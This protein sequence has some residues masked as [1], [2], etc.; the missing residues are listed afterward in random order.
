[1]RR[2]KEER[3][4]QNERRTEREDVYIYLNDTDTVTPPPSGEMI[5]PIIRRDSYSDEKE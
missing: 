4:M 2:K 1:M 3:D 5:V